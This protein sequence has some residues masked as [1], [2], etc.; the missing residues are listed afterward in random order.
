[1]AVLR[2]QHKFDEALQAYYETLKRD[3]TYTKAYNNIATVY[4][5]K[6]EFSLEAAINNFPDNHQFVS[7]ARAKLNELR[8]I[9]R[10]SLTD[11]TSPAANY[12]SVKVFYGSVQ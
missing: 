1:L 7:A 5:L 12:K 9:S 10:M 8:K 3:E 2:N 11:V 4:L 6:A